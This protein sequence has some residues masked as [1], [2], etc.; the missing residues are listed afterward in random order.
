LKILATADYHSDGEAFRRTAVKADEL[1][2]DIVTIC[3]DITH[4]GSVTEGRK[5]LQSIAH[6]NSSI[7]FIPGNCDPPSLIEKTGNLECIHGRCKQIRNLN[8]LGVGGSSPSPFNTPFELEEI[9]I[10]ELLKQGLK[11]CNKHME[12]ILVSH[13]P[14]KN[15]A[16]D[17]TYEKAHV[18]SISVRDFIEKIKPLLVVCGHIHESPGVDTI[19]GSIIVNPGP[20]RHKRCAIIDLTNEI[21]VKLDHL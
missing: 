10:A 8:F 6:I 18:G 4:F 15:T 20:A 9:D 13:S 7:L 1:E 5:L 12:S 14:P 3:G 2:I 21:K 16:V 19:N 11:S 17:M